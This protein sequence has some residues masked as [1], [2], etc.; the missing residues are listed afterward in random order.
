[1]AGGWVGIVKANVAGGWVGIVKA[2]VAGGWV[3]IVKANVAGG[4]VGIV[5]ANVAGG[6]VGIVKANVAGGWVGIV[7][8]KN[9]V[10]VTD[11][12]SAPVNANTACNAVTLPNCWGASLRTLTSVW[13]FPDCHIHS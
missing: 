12:F 6:W 11:A 7:K 10:E 3:G 13:L 8:A 2:N 5:K 1:V 4:W 9:G